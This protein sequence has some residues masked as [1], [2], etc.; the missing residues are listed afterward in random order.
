MLYVSVFGCG[1]MRDVHVKNTP[2]LALIKV[3][4]LTGYKDTLTYM[5][6]HTRTN[7]QACMKPEATC[8]LKK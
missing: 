1:K 7:I 4:W 2:T 8:T 3:A 5:H 6:T